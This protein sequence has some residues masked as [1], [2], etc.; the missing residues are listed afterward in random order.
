MKNKKKRPA[1]VFKNYSFLFMI[2]YRNLK[3]ESNS[4]CLNPVNL[5]M[6]TSFKVI[7]KSI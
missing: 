6:I 2:M 3:F 7:T 4:S 1:E 5:L